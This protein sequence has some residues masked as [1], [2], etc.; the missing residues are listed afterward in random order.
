MPGRLLR[1]YKRF[2]ADVR[3]DTGR[4]VTAHCPN[5]GSMLGLAEPGMP[6]LLSDSRNPQRKL[7][8]TLEMVK[9]GRIW[10]GVNTQRPNRVVTEA[11]RRGKVAELAGYDRIRNEVPYGKNSRIDVLLER[12]PAEDPER[13]YV[14]VKNTTLSGGDGH[15][16]ARF[17]DAVTARGLKHL[18]ELIR[19]RRKGNRAVMVYL[20]NRADC[21]TFA[22][23]DDIDPAYGNGLRKA[24]RAG[25]EILPLQARCT[26]RG[27][28]VLGTLPFTLSP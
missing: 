3:L 13:C 20:V 4:T 11:I 8:L 5:P 27:I 26:R 18:D 2:L 28:S 14:E 7:R 19:E 21:R 6:V 22:P 9:V 12:G 15:T 24:H 23:A 16:M 25:V 1:R 10:V 17:P